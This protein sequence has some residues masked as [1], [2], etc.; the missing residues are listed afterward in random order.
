V[1]S[2]LISNAIKYAP[3]GGEICIAGQVR[4]GEAPAEEVR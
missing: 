3:R 2:N 4:A 1:F